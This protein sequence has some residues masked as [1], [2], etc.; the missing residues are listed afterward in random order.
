MIQA[1]FEK[2]R[3][4][5]QQRAGDAFSSYWQ[6]VVKPLAERRELDEESVVAAAES[7]GRD[8]EQVEQDV[9]LYLRRCQMNSELKAVPKWRA[10]ATRLQATIDQASSELRE[11]QQ[12]LQTIIDSAYATKMQVE[13]RIDGTR[14]H[15]TDLARTCPNPAL[16]SRERELSEQRRELLSKRQPLIESISDSGPG[17]L[18]SALRHCENQ[19]EEYQDLASRGDID[20]RQYV[21][22]IKENVIAYETRIKL[23][24][25]QLNDIDEM[26]AQLDREIAQIRT[27]KLQ[28]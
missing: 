13:A 12:R 20:A 25:N 6:N 14:S 4:K 26:I 16:Q 27:M 11:H 15:E 5:S 23:A 21:Q 10:E 17:S 19:R 1:L 8:A 22:R 24:Q 2:V 18:G 7:V 3:R 28:P 9:A